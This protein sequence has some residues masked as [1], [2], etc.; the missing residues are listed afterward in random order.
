MLFN[1]RKGRLIGLRSNCPMVHLRQI[2]Q[3]KKAEHF[4]VLRV[5]VISEESC[6]CEERKG[7]RYATRSAARPEFAPQ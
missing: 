7:A 6:V 1:S 3:S 2:V 5:P 4:D